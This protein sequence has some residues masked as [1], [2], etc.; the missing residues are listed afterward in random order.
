MRDLRAWISSASLIRSN[1]VIRACWKAVRKSSEFNEVATR[2]WAIADATV[3]SL[4]ELRSQLATLGGGR[5]LPERTE[6][7]G[8]RRE[9]HIDGPTG[10]LN[11]P[12]QETLRKEYGKLLDSLTP[13]DYC[14]IAVSNWDR[15]GLESLPPHV[16]GRTFIFL[17]ATA[18]AKVV[19]VSR[20]TWV[21]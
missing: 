18:P 2:R 13:G 14:E 8:R 19:S 4:D 9:K 11:R 21:T 17:V 1:P 12:D 10:V 3:V 5:P 16:R 7:R 6:T 20:G 15:S